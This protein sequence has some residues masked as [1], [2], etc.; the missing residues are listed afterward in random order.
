M[1]TTRSVVQKFHRTVTN[2]GDGAATY[3]AKVTHPE[4]SVVTVSPETLTFSYK[5]EKQSYSVVIKYKWHKKKENISFGDL[6]WVEDG[7]AHTVRSPI[8]VAPSLV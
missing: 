8:V 2:V 3:R 6:V 5:H 4:G 7:G 1:V